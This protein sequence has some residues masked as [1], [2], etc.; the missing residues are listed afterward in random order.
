MSV[1]SGSMMNIMPFR[2]ESEALPVSVIQSTFAFRKLREAKGFSIEDV[3]ARLKFTARQIQW[4]EA[5]EFDR[6]PRGVALKGMIKNY[7]KLLEVDADAILDALHPFIGSVSGG[8]S[9]HTSTRSLGTH[10]SSHH[11]GNGTALWVVMIMTVLLVAVG[12]AIWQGI[13]PQGWLPG[14]IGAMFK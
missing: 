5:E 11:S 14:W 1:E 9:Q 12:V 6:L 4:L 7:A 2:T 8:I 10:D 3:A 13:I